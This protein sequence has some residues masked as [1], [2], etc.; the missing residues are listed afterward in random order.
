MG[1]RSFKCSECEIWKLDP[2]ALRDHAKA[3]H[4][5]ELEFAGNG[6]FPKTKKATTVT[7]EDADFAAIEARCLAHFIAEGGKVGELYGPTNRADRDKWKA[8][9]HLTHYGVTGRMKD[10]IK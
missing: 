8:R 10:E 5:V 7:I 3:K 4:G 1:G 2:G 9:N 6:P